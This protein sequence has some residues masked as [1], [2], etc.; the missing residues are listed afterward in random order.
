M[1]DFDEFVRAWNDAVLHWVSE[2][3]F[4]KVMCSCA[5]VQPTLLKAVPSTGYKPIAGYSA[6]G[7][8]EHE[9]V[10]KVTALND[11]RHI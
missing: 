3:C 4:D 6:E 1:S 8:Y 5:G 11:L 10:R 7:A 2:E 9:T